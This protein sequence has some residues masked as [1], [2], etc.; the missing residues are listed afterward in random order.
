MAE[1]TPRALIEEHRHAEIVEQLRR[2]NTG[3]EALH[4]LTE[5]QIGAMANLGA[6]VEAALQYFVRAWQATRGAPRN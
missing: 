5:R 3:L 2:I 6:K 1:R 4:L